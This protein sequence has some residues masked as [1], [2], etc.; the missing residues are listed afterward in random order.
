MHKFLIIDD[1]PLF[2]E[3]IQLVIQSVYPKAEMHEAASV[4]AAIEVISGQRRGYDLALLDLSMPG[5]KG[6]DGLLMIRSRFPRLPILMISG[7]DD[8][9][10]VREALSY[11]IS[12]FASKSAKKAELAQAVQKV[13]G[14]SVYLPDGYESGATSS[15]RPENL[16]L[17][18]RLSSLTSQQM[19]VL[20][21]LRQ[22]KFNKEIA[23]ELDVG[24]TTVKAHISGILR[25][26]NVLSRTQAVIET[27][28]INFNQILDEDA[29]H[30]H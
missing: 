28:K 7:L 9:G 14:G 20:K 25:K 8:Q 11:G 21:M 27:S 16:E 26:L 3:A 12:G 6:F 24:E 19:R 2:R 13:I 1:H 4:D 5:T 17:I 18:A 22:G 30:Q 10:V 15:G 23:H 29:G